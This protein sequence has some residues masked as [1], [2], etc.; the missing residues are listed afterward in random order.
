[1]PL[2]VYCLIFIE[3]IFVSWGDIKNKKIP[4]LWSILNI[5]IFFI[6][7]FTYSE[8]YSFTFKTLFFSFAFFFVGF[9][10]F[11]L[12]I[13]GGGDSKF[14]ASLFLLI[15]L[16][17]QPIFLQVLLILTV[18]VG[19]ILLTYNTLNN[20]EKI[21]TKIYLRD[22]GGFKEIYGSKF[23]YAPLIM[24]SWIVFGYIVFYDQKLL[25]YFQ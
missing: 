1:M 2:L 22:F 6:F 23:T 9:G 12:N 25:R 19:I 20:F 8:I 24:V 17:Q 11:L 4:N 15:P 3:L 16:T 5:L 14:L 21:K 13:M 10:L 7:I 18:I